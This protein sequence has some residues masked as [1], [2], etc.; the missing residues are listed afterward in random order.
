MENPVIEK[1]SWAIDPA[2][3][4]IHFKVKHMTVSTVTGAFNEF[5]GMISS[6]NEDFSDAEISF[7]AEVASISTNNAQRDEHL[8]SDD[9]FNAAKY[10]KLTFK[11]SSFTRNADGE[12]SLVGD[13]TIRDNTHEVMLDVEYNGTA[14][15]P[16]GQTKAGFEISGKINRKEYGLKWGAVTEAG[17]VV[18]S[19]QVKLVM[20]VQLTRQ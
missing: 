16:Y 18:V 15:D 4:E 19:D 6:E 5:E 7:S 2:H 11:S 17:G 12:Y 3:S 20:N 14:V 9:F 1:T 13:L 8:K 10:P